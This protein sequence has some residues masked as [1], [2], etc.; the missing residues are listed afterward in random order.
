MSPQK[1]VTLLFGSQAVL[2][3]NE[4]IQASEQGDLNLHPK[5]NLKALVYPK[6]NNESLLSIGQLCDKGRIAVFSKKSLISSKTI[7]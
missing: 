4:R 6:L 3:N 1:V 5:I 7:I 2:P